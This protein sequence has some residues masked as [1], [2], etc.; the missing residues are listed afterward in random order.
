MQVEDDV[1]LPEGRNVQF[2]G[3][4]QARIGNFKVPRVLPDEH[5]LSWCGRMYRINDVDKRMD[6]RMSYRSFL[7]FKIEG[8]AELAFLAGM[9]PEGLLRRHTMVPFVRA[10]VPDRTFVNSAGQR[11]VD[12]DVT[13]KLAARWG[14]LRYC[15]SCVARDR[16]IRGFAYWRRMHQLP[17]VFWCPQH[18]HSLI[19]TSERTTYADEPGDLLTGTDASQGFWPSLSEVC[20]AVRAY[21]HLAIRTLRR[22]SPIGSSSMTVR[23][24][25]MVFALQPT[26]LERSGMALR[27]KSA[28]E[29][30]FPVEWLAR[31]SPQRIGVAR[32]EAPAEWK[33]LLSVWPKPR[34]TER[35]LIIA[36]ALLS[37]EHKVSNILFSPEHEYWIPDR[38]Y[39]SAPSRNWVIA[40][41]MRLAK[42]IEIHAATSAFA[43]L[44]INLESAYAQFLGGSSIEE[45]CALG[46]IDPATFQDFL[47]EQLLKNGLNRGGRTWD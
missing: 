35:Y 17:G 45:S 7:P 12:S 20:P 10:V 47:R 18:K 36:A 32:G 16:R 1:T 37:D 28:V 25:A 3:S 26:G 23:L 33:T 24:N 34:A 44:L 6:P 31:V 13:P 11:N 42:S 46:Q 4:L 38:T 21:V 40:A 5:V 43:P 41:A 2:V 30:A 29:G 15:P 19:A 27:L 8:L 14:A 9:D 22:P 39:P